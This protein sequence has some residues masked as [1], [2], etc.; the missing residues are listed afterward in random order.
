MTLLAK[1]MFSIVLCAG[2]AAC[3]SETSSSDVQSTTSTSTTAQFT[4]SFVPDHLIGMSEAA[5]T[6]KAQS[7]NYSVRVVE[8]DGESLIVTMDYSDRRINLTINDD[9]VMK[10][11]I[12]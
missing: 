9:I 7:E 10:T 5:A 12:G 3:S 6:A 4:S 2:L 1:V 8:R 11:S